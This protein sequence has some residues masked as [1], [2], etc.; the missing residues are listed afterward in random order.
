M[1]AE[2]SA[3]EALAVRNKRIREYSNKILA[4][5]EDIQNLLLPELLNATPDAREK[6]RIFR[7]WNPM[8]LDIANG[9]AVLNQ[10]IDAADKIIKG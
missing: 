6:N 4:E 9:L 1:S 3:K 5:V 10:G 7:K 2:E 8:V